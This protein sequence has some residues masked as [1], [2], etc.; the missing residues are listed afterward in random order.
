MRVKEYDVIVIGSGVGM[1]IVEETLEHG[2]DVALVDK[3]PLGGT[4]PNLGC[5]PSKMLIASADRI[6]E[7]Q[8]AKRIGVTLKVE[9]IDF[10]AIMERQ[11][12]WVRE[13]QRHMRE[14]IKAAEN[15]DFYEGEGHFVDEYTL[16]V[17]GE[18]IKGGK[19]FI[20][21]G[22]RTLVPPIKGL[23][24][25]EYLTNESVLQ[26][27]KRPDS[28][29]IMGGGYIA[30]EYGHFFAAMGTKVTIVEMAERL[31]LSEDIEVSH[32]LQE[33]LLSRMAVYTSAP[34]LEV[35][36]APEGVT[37]VTGEGKSR[38]EHTGQSVL[39]AVGRRSNADV[40]KADKT[41]VAL[42]SR[43]YIKVNEHMETTKKNVYAV[44]DADG[45]QMFTHVGN[46]EAV[47]AAD[48]A[49][50][51]ARF[52][53]DYSA[54]PHA[55]YS[56]PQIAS[57]GLTE[58]AARKLNKKLLVGRVKYFDVAKGE[59][60]METKGFAKAIVEEGTDKILGFHVIG[61]YAPIIIQEVTNAMASGSHI[62]AIRAGMHIHPEITELVPWAFSRLS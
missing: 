38:R 1:N 3:G 24:T 35:K 6:V 5:I 37:V 59:A 17:N 18:R 34:V 10:L 48:V 57:V 51:G 42:D 28:L 11:R 21:S 50:H 54:A 12:Q 60:I 58:E 25:V 36:K 55:V 16:E 7:A 53:M 49:I 40:L 13:N 20:A 56:H 32:L 45:V 44:G 26:L 31:V 8:E 39:L 46:R 33:E 27:T 15:L 47:L 14:G 22:S 30:A 52:K 4:C 23:D 43:G 61:P 41:G 29:I 19:V 62:D 2:M 9:D